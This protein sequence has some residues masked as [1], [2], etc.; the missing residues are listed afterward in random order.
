[1]WR[2]TKDILRRLNRQLSSGEIAPD[3]TVADLFHTTTAANG[4]DAHT[5]V[6][7]INVKDT[8]SGLI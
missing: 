8:R 4:F 1:M 5:G 2:R 7:R 6:V 3:K